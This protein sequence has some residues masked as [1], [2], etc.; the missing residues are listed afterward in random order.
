MF[1]HG[2]LGEEPDIL[3]FPRTWLIDLQSRCSSASKIG[4]VSLAG[5]PEQGAKGGQ[6]PLP[7]D[8]WDNRC[9]SYAAH[10]LGFSSIVC[11]FLKLLYKSKFSLHFAFHIQ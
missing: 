3:A 9:P 6:R 2:E 1:S 10:F 8:S 4:N 11:S 5:T 7:L